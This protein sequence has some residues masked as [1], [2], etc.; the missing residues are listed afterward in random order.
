[1]GFITPA[2]G[3]ADVFV[4]RSN[5]IDGDALIVGAPVV[6]EAGFDP[7]KGKPIAKARTIDR[8]VNRDK[9]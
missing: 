8:H 5:L 7:Q 9:L 6:F 3:S 4:H 1:M 2:D